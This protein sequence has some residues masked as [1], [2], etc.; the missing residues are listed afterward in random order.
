MVRPIAICA[1]IASLFVVQAAFAFGTSLRTGTPTQPSQHQCILC[2]PADA[3][4]PKSAPIV[5]VGFGIV[6]SDGNAAGEAA[7][8]PQSQALVARH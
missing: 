5:V 6:L 4:T 2:A 8:A 1:I 3:S 7:A